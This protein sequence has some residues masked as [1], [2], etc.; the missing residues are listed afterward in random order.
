MIPGTPPAIVTDCDPIRLGA[1]RIRL[2]DIDAPEMA[3]GA[4]CELSVHWPKSRRTSS[5][6]SSPASDS[7][8]IAAVGIASA[9]HWPIS[10]SAAQTSVDS[11]HRACRRVGDIS[12]AVTF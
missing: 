5:T 10:A 8:S 6:S 7:R 9:A 12:G 3:S 1:E 2:I 11:D 4:R